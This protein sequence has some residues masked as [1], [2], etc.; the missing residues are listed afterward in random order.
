[1]SQQGYDQNEFEGYHA[2]SHGGSFEVFYADQREHGKEVNGLPIV[3][4]EEGGDR[5]EGWYWWVCLPG[6]L[7]DGEPSGPF[8]TSEGAYLDAIGD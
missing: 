5:P 2:F 6:C 3:V 7:P 8:P 4:L 1:M